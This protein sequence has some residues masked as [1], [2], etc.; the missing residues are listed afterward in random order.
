[1][2][3]EKWRTENESEDNLMS[4][5]QEAEQLT[6]RIVSQCREVTLLYNNLQNNQ[7]WAMLDADT[8]A[9]NAVDDY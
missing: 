4:N 1:M 2:S 6:G 8:E 7:Q 9:V 3:A 5:R